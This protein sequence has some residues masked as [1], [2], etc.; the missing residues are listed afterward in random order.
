M[1][2]GA[3]A[4]NPAVPNAAWTRMNAVERS[5]VAQS[6]AV[7]PFVVGAVALLAPALHTISD[8]VE[9]HNGG[10]TAFQLGLNLVAFL[11]MPLLLLGLW[12]VQVPRPGTAGLVGAL[13]YGTAF[14]YFTWTTL[15]A[16]TEHLPTYEA[17]WSR[18]GGTYTFF[19][20]AM[21]IGGVLFAVSAMRA[22]W[23]PR[24]AVLV[25]LAG[26]VVNLALALLPAP[27]ILQTIGS[28][29]RN[30]GL[31]AMGHALLFR[32]ATPAARIGH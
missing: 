23:Y 10:F 1:L 2:A 6:G 22:G 30:L 17:L 28:A 31:M 19:G 7:L 13:L 5:S 21:V 24:F 14:A 27:D 25:F 26:L 18:L 29:M 8:V 3:F 12:A 11:P 32:R 16:M 15:Y 9:W 4:S 20:A